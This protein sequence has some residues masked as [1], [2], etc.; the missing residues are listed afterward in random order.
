MMLNSRGASSCVS[1]AGLEASWRTGCCAAWFLF[2]G[3]SAAISGL[4]A[5]LTRPMRQGVFGG[6][7]HCCGNRLRGRHGWHR[8]VPDRFGSRRSVG[9][10]YDGRQVSWTAPA[11][12]ARR[13]RHPRAD[14]W[15]PG[16]GRRF[17][18][19]RRP[20]TLDA[21]VCLVDVGCRRVLRRQLC[22]QFDHTQRGGAS[23]LGAGDSRA[24]RQQSHG[25]THCG[26]KTLPLK[27]AK[28][29][30][31]LLGWFSCIRG[32]AGRG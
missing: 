22:T 32:L 12:D 11:D 2:S 19:W 1:G 20:G 21:D 29:V 24:A 9:I 31:G 18:R 4:D 27:S 16:R 30:R 3:C 23:R 13:R 14:S 15:T 17:S 7:D 28:S 10:L 6:F 26:V 25:G 5:G 8:G